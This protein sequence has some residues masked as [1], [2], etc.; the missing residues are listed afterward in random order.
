[1]VKF[2]LL[3]FGDTHQDV[4]ATSNHFLE[5]V[6]GNNVY[7]FPHPMKVFF[8]ENPLSLSL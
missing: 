2:G 3:I 7:K 5:K 4:D 1:M 6:I 8:N